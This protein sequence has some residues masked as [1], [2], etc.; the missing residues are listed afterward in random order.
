MVKG[1]RGDLGAADTT[2]GQHD[3]Q[4]PAVHG[5]GAENSQG[6]ETHAA[7]AGGQYQVILCICPTQIQ[8][9]KTFYVVSAI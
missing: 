2:S 5:E 9:R 8:F 1:C 3:W 4:I 6:L 7:A